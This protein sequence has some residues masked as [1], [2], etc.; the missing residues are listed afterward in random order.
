MDF[1]Q[2]WHIDT[3]ESRQYIIAI[4]G[5]GIYC[6]I[7]AA[8]D[9][10]NDFYGVE[11]TGKKGTQKD[12]LSSIGEHDR[13]YFKDVQKRREGSWDSYEGEY[14]VLESYVLTDMSGQKLFSMDEV[15]FFSEYVYVI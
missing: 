5:T 15:R 9:L 2:A 12:L 3:M 7:R 13:V 6:G 11:I 4:N 1:T 8:L 14:D 10:H